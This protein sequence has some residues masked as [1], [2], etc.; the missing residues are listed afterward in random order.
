LMRYQL[1]R[2]G[3]TYTKDRFSQKMLSLNQSLQDI[4]F[5]L[6]SRLFGRREIL[7]SQQ[8]RLTVE[9]RK[10]SMWACLSK[11]GIGSDS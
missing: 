11:P 1:Q 6:T 7:F 8:S 10:R 3:K 2:V 4:G 5:V 9:V